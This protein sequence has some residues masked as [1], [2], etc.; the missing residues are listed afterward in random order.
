V[1][2]ALFLREPLVQFIL[3]GAVLFG[4]YRVR[5]A[6]AGPQNR[7]PIPAIGPWMIRLRPLSPVP[8]PFE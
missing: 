6:K 2:L 3:I 4:A 7:K 8:P 1:T 5:R